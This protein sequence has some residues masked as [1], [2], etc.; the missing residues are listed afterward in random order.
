MYSRRRLML[1]GL[2]HEQKGCLD[3]LSGGT[4]HRQDPVLICVMDCV[5]WT[6][7][8]LDPH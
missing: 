8:H 4:L 1:Q 6:L 7:A 2:P 3:C 5:W